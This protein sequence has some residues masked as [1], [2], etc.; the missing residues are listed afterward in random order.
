MIVNTSRPAKALQVIE[1]RIRDIP[2]DSRIANDV[3]ERVDTTLIQAPNST[4]PWSPLGRLK[5]TSSADC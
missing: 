4:Y 2:Q 3:G 1:H 5:M